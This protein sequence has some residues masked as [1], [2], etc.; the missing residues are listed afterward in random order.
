VELSLVSGRPVSFIQNLYPPYYL[1][2]P[3]LPLA[4]AGTA[5]AR[6]HATGFANKSKAEADALFEESDYEYAA[7]KQMS[8]AEIRAR[9]PAPSVN[10]IQTAASG[11]V[12]GDQF[13]YKV[14]SPVNL[15]RRQSAMIPLVQGTVLGQKTLIL[16]GSRS[17]T[18]NPELGVELTNNTG[19]KLPA[20]P[21]TVYD[22]L[23]A[24]DA[25]IEFFAEGDKRLI[26]YGEDLAITASSALNTSRVIATVTVNQGVMTFNRRQIFEKTYTIK[27][28][29]SEA[30]RII[31]EH[32]ITGN[33]E[34][35]EPKDFTEKTPSHYRYVRS[36]PAKGELVFVVKEESPL[37]EAVSLSSLRRDSLLSYSTN[38][39]IPAAVRQALTRAASLKQKA[40]EER[41]SL[42]ALETGKQR[43]TAEQDRI[44]NNLSAVGTSSD[45]GKEYMRRMTEL[46]AQIQKANADIEKATAQSA[47]AQKDFDTYLQ[48]LKL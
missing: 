6:T 30:R 22:G 42:A 2:R 18:F 11:S 33:A 40:E 4:I 37:S 1:A 12:T 45:L 35:A 24:G 41:S 23:Y 25:L 10:A 26:S 38:S 31:I 19:M 29:G 39:E 21:I 34:I 7:A 15:P 32:P 47:A 13:S 5:E 17:G 16:N 36:L 3:T 43:L 20:G 27:N 28:A 46:D 8:S 9:S 14:S 48:N 44:R